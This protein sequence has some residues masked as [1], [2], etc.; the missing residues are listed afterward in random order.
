MF[1]PMSREEMSQRDW[2]YIDY[3]LVSGDAY[4]DH[5]SLPMLLSDDG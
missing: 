1:L 4:V 5:P 3:L 2:H